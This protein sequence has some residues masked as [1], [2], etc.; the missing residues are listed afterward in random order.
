M[1]YELNE[2]DYDKVRPLFRPLVEYAPFCGAVLEGLYSGRVYV[3]DPARPRTAFMV[4]RDVWG[5]L[6]GDPGNGAFNQ[7]LNEAIFARNAVSEDAL[8]LIISC[9][10]E[11]REQVAVMCAPRQPIEWSR[12]HYVCRE[13]DY[14]W[15]ANV[16]EGFTIRRVDATLLERPEGEI[17]D[18]VKAVIAVCG[19]GDD[20]LEK[21]FGF[22]ACHGDEVV[23]HAVV[24]CIVGGVGEIGLETAGAYQRR[25]LATVTSAAAVEFGLSHGLSVISWDCLTTNTGSVRTAEKLGFE[26]EREHQMYA[27]NFDAAWHLVNLAW[28]H[29]R[30]VRYRE[31]IE[32]CEQFIAQP[33]QQGDPL[34]Y[35]Y[36]MAA[37]AWGGLGDQGQAFEYLDAVVDRG[38]AY[39]DETENCEE[40][41]S[42]HGTP[43]WTGVLERIRQN[44]QK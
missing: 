24:D 19:P 34:L 18:D 30:A 1:I 21:G 22:V 15:Q 35:A 2:T 41:E 27:I 23:A 28:G 9:C 13:L 6:A 4:T 29:L 17:H 14:D 33:G 43:E 16:P 39:I 25:G 11:W 40:F 42:W 20:P 10:P 44:G 5:Y 3:D 12:R 36:H 7:A 38:W 26:P 8:V 31:A 37:Q 32:V